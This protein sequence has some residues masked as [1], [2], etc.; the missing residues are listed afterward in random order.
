MSKFKVG[1]R[2]KNLTDGGYL[3]YPIGMV[4]VVN[5]VY[6]TN[7]LFQVVFEEVDT[8]K[9]TNRLSW[10]DFELEKLED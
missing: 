4:G 3:G 8:S 2:V 9:N 1:D 7:D 10:Y 5:F 6:A